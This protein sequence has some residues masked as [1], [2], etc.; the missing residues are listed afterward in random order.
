MN[1]RRSILV[2]LVLV[3]FALSCERAPQRATT[4]VKSGAAV[5]DAGKTDALLS[6][7]A[8]PDGAEGDG[9]LVEMVGVEAGSV[10]GTCHVK[11]TQLLEAQIYRGPGVDSPARE[12]TMRNLPPGEAA[13]WRGR[14]HGLLHLA[15]TYELLVNGKKYRHRH[16]GG[17]SVGSSRSLD[18]K[19]CGTPEM[20]EKAEASVRIGNPT[21]QIH[22]V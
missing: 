19:S 18:A 17:Q 6:S 10:A 12:A 21:C 22:L 2:A 8:E 7:V 1:M 5:L 14:D 16:L 11:I 13:R 15:C 4:P 20:R 9:A 3:G